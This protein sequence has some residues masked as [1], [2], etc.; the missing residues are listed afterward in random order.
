MSDLLACPCCAYPTLSTR[1]D[2]E[3]CTICWWEDDGQDDRNAD[4][5]LGGPN[6]AYSLT[7]ARKNFADHF[8]MYDPGKG[9]GVVASPSPERKTLLAYLA[10]VK[11]GERAHDLR[12]LQG[13][14]RTDSDARQKAMQ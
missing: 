13:L 14:L 11:Q 7:A 9:I 12:I 5:V 1:G 10:A 8:D 2:F 6:G 3:I 4:E